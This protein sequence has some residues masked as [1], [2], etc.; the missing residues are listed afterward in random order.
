MVEI[1][2]EMQEALARL[3]EVR[4]TAPDG[5]VSARL[6][7]T[8][9]LFFET[10]G[11]A[12]GQTA[13]IGA[14]FGLARDSEP[15]F[16]AAQAPSGSLVGYDPDALEAEALGAIARGF[17]QPLAHPMDAPGIDI[18][19]WPVPRP[20]LAGGDMPPPSATL[21]MGP[22]FIEGEP[23]LSELVFDTDIT[24][25]GRTGPEPII[26]RILAA[27][28]RLRP[29]H[30]LAGF[31]I[32]FN[33]VTYSD[34]DGYASFPAIKRFPGLHCAQNSAFATQPV[35]SLPGPMSVNWLTILGDPMIARLADG[36]L[37]TLPETC[38]VTAYDGGA[39][40]RAGALPQTGDTNRA[41][42][43]A[44]Y[45]A[46]A[47]VLEDILFTDYSGPLFAVPQPLDKMDETRAWVRR[48]N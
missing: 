15:G 30:G 18:G 36:G 17:A 43:L 35:T 7:F 10:G 23:R 41:L 4:L 37:D 1:T 47:Q 9:T 46:V 34:T 6:C 42:S 11:T 40:I 22:A 39:L 3:A 2:S 48:F 16:V 5:R 31:S 25:I 8:T 21:V 14:F 28:Q 13:A 33:Q 12:E 44:P 29:I 24:E 20:G 27:A 32:H 38:P 45:N 19:L 26:A